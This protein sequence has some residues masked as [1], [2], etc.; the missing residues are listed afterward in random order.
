MF[1][2]A[3]LPR[4]L[5]QL[6]QRPTLA[7]PATFLTR[8]AIVAAG[9]FTMA[10][11]AQLSIRLPWT[12]VPI[13]GQTFGVSLMA[14][15]YG[16]RLGII[17]MATYILLGAFG[18]PV[19]AAGQALALA[20]MVG[21]LAGMVVSAAVI[22]FMA[23]RGFTQ[24]FKQSFIACLIGSACV[25]SLGLLVLSTFIPHSQLLIAGLLPFIP[26][27]LVKSAIASLISTSARN[28]LS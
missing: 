3:A 12:P 26:G 18:A 15:L 25:F 5:S 27:D 1:S 24:T 10:L 9:V 28:R 19:F 7:R 16:R 17:T 23:D 4:I 8:A 21:Y 6:D 14:L 13:T 20:P 2:D 11:L 22:G